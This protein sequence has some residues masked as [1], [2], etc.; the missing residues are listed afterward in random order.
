MDARYHYEA[1]LQLLTGLFMGLLTTV[2][3]GFCS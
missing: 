2:S 1:H 3:E